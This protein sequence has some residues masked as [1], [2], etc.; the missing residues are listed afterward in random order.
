MAAEPLPE[1]PNGE[2]K[3]TATQAYGLNFMNMVGTGPFVTIPLVLGS[4]HAS[5]G[6]AGLFG[7]AA[8]GVLC[9]LDSFIWAELGST[10]RVLSRRL[11]YIHH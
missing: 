8:A 4:A 9:I 3:L 5:N 2:G 6:Y 10:V 11:M 1:A 7:Y